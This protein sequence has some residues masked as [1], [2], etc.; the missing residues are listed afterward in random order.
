MLS[1]DCQHRSINSIELHINTADNEVD[2]IDKRAMLSTN[3]KTFDYLRYDSYFGGSAQ[4][5]H[6]TKIHHSVA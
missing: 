1:V 4:F 2:I 3:E 5:G 6:G